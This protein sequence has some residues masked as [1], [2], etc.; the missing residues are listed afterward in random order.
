[1]VRGGKVTW[2]AIES[3][4]KSNLRV[5]TEKKLEWLV[6]RMMTSD[7]RKNL[8]LSSFIPNTYILKQFS[9][10]VKKCW[11]HSPFKLPSFHKLFDQCATLRLF[12]ARKWFFSRLLLA[13]GGKEHR[14]APTRGNSLLSLALGNSSIP[15]YT[16]RLN[17]KFIAPCSLRVL[18]EESFGACYV[19]W[20]YPLPLWRNTIQ[21]FQQQ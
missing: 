14:C 15:R 5:I 11:T 4:L 6:F 13:E 10:T 17:K 1:M 21:S 20:L 16:Q 2:N 7:V 19:I 12:K 9:S 18:Q 3:V 8:Y